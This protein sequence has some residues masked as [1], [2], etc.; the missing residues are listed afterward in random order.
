M[1]KRVGWMV[2]FTALA[3]SLSGCCCC[4]LSGQETPRE[5]ARNI[6]TGPTQQVEHQIEL[7]DASRVQ[8]TVGF[9]GGTLNIQG[10]AE[11]LL[12]GEFTYNLDDLKPVVEYEKEG[13]VGKLVIRHQVD[14]L[15]WDPTVEVRNEWQLNLSDRVPLEMN[16]DV[17]GS[18]GTLELGGLRL[19]DLDLTAGAADMT[20]RFREPNPD[21]LASFGV[22][23]GAA[24]LR[25]LDL[26]NANM[27]S[28][29][30][31]GG[32]GTYVFDFEGAW[33][34]SAEVHIQAGAS[35][36]ELRVPR[37]I[38]VRVCPGDLRSGDYDGLV[39]QDECYV[40]DLYGQTDIQLQIDLD[41]GLGYLE[42]NQIN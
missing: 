41:L 3:L 9:G 35:R 30:F 33:Q 37:D 31:D 23:S 22:H 32:L 18:N 6:N 15:N 25:L 16:L 39:A 10:G 17:G 13:E 2:L 20:V 12:D 38:G 24:R 19:T 36:V 27:D 26:G 14:A 34:R 8:V 4:C 21:Q 28:L 40:N 11:N 29:S 7:Q 5:L 1:I 42:V